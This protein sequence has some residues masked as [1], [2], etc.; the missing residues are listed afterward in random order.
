MNTY[1]KLLM[2]LAILP[3]ALHAQNNLPVD[4]VYVEGGLF[5]TQVY[6]SITNITKTYFSHDIPS[7]RIGSTEVSVQDFKQFCK[8]TGRNMPPEPDWGWK[9]PKR[10]IVN[11][12]YADAL[13]YCDWLSNKHGILFTL[14]TRQQWEY[15]ARAG[16]FDT[17][18]FMNNQELPN[19]Y[20]VYIGNSKEKPECITC[21]QPNELGLYALCGNVW[22]WVLAEPRDQGQ[23][24][25]V[26]GSFFESADH[27][28]IN[29]SQRYSKDLRRQDI[30]FRVVINTD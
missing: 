23:S 6:D 1:K 9:D 25:V 14:P 11:V 8:E 13:A 5:G 3:M 16:N 28:R 17:P 24:T 29:S 26:G 20:V 30:G 18:D 7:F 15:A 2:I 27:V 10:P 22:E 12:T 21:M 19:P 4:M